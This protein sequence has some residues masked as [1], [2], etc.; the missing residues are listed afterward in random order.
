MARSNLIFE[1]LKNAWK[2]VSKNK[3]LVV[4]IIVLN[5]TFLILWFGNS[6]FFQER[7]T[8]G[9]INITETLDNDLPT[10]D[11]IT[12]GIFS[13]QSLVSDGFVESMEIYESILKDLRMWIIISGILFALI[14]GLYWSFTN[15]LFEDGKFFNYYSRFIIV[16]IVYF[17]IIIGIFQLVIINAGFK[18]ESSSYIFFIALLVIG[19]FMPITNSLLGNMKLKKVVKKTLEIAFGKLP[20]I[21][22]M[23]LLCGIMIGLPLY[24]IVL[25]NSVVDNVFVMIISGLIM[26][27]VMTY[28]RAF[29]M[30][31]VNQAS[32]E[33]SS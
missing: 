4:L 21:I 28:V 24:L 20:W 16:S 5:L 14:G 3:L 25:L 31:L 22:L 33:L 11:E 29:I 32:S 18:A 27:L 19:Y 23:Y 1:A 7:V 15:S 9:L 8:E 26:L 12:Q 13:G 10:D 30:S 6:L 2:G 17:L